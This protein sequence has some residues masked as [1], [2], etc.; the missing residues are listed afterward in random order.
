MGAQLCTLLQ[1]TP[2][3]QT[4]TLEGFDVEREGAE[5]LAGSICTNDHL[6]HLR[7]RRCEIR[8]VDLTLI[9]ESVLVNRVLKTFDVG[10]ESGD[11]PP[12][13]VHSIC[14]TISRV[15]QGNASLV[16]F[17]LPRLRINVEDMEI[18]VEGLRHNKNIKSI[19][20]TPSLFNDNGACLDVLKNA[21]LP[22]GPSTLSLT[23]IRLPIIGTVSTIM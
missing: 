5:L 18:L 21:L 11:L 8:V 3:L 14:Q 13:D 22:E 15:F 1:I 2:G 7:L 19:D 17:E 12:A 20:F 23:A 9:L 16:N 6:E 4:L 10:G